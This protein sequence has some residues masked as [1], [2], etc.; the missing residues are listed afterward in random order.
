ME[1][2]HRIK[3]YIEYDKAID[4]NNS[5]HISVQKI[6]H[7]GPVILYFNKYIYQYNKTIE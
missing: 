3:V 4:L 1:L 5:D 2:T 7:G 6:K